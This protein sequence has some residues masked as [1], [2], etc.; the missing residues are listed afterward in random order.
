[1]H[2][3]SRE[4]RYE[5]LEMSDGGVPV[6]PQTKPVCLGSRVWLCLLVLLLI[7][8]VTL[9]II[10]WIR[11]AGSS[12]GSD[13]IDTS[14]PAIASLLDMNNPMMHLQAL[15]DIA[16][17]ESRALGTKGYADS[18]AYVKSQLEGT[19][20]I[21][22]EQTFKVLGWKFVSSSFSNQEDETEYV[23][24][25]NYTVL[26]YSGSTPEG[27]LEAFASV[28]SGNRT[29]CSPNDYLGWSQSGSIVLVSRGDCTFYVKA[30]NAAAAGAGAILVYNNQD[31][32]F[33]GTASPEDEDDPAP[34]IAILGLPKALGLDLVA[35]LANYS[36]TLRV[37]V[38]TFTSMVETQ[39]VLADTTGGDPD[40]TV[41]LGSHLDSVP[42]GAGIN[43]NGSGSAL[44]L[45]LALLMD[46]LKLTPRNRVRFAWWGA[47]EV[48][49]KGSLHYVDKIPPGELA[50]ISANIN[51]DMLAS[52]NYQIGIYDGR[53]DKKTP[54]AA[55]IQ[56][57]YEEW[58]LNMGI[59]GFT[60][61]PYDGRSDY[62]GFQARGIPAGGVFA[63]AE[64]IKTP[65]EAEAYGVGGEANKSYDECYHMACDN[66]Y[67]INMAGYDLMSRST[68]HV[69][70]H[71][72]DHP[73][74]N[75]LL[76]IDVNTTNVSAAASQDFKA[77]WSIYRRAGQFMYLG[78]HLVR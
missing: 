38:A 68:A 41:I 16:G 7:L 45:A 61:I 9:G 72:F 46:E 69:L 28:P 60:T 19:S 51:I 48:G 18:V 29:G 78:S 58:F 26:A 17:N 74:L 21:V 59:P 70:Q 43:D 49:L 44:T 2:F 10:G 8:A 6:R 36:L 30:K 23:L 34:S 27:G 50:Q 4:D 20:L 65:K 56:E 77:Q 75:G 35:Y 52:P 76:Q 55:V 73:D 39:N 40:Q 3:A 13:K 15:H 32:L 37:S 66:V 31:G 64:G 24:D 5:D 67:N 1:M 11:Q 42:A 25:K 33:L 62:A 53:S 57:L 71:L 63:G 12:T 22:Q 54:G 47:E 14:R